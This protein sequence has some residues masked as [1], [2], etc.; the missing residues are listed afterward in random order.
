MYLR[1][2]ST[3]SLANQLL[4]ISSHATHQLNLKQ[5]PPG[6]CILNP[7]Y[8]WT[9]HTQWLLKLCFWHFMQVLT[10]SAAKQTQK[11]SEGRMAR[12]KPT[13]YWLTCHRV[14]HPA[15]VEMRTN[16][17]PRNRRMWVRWTNCFACL[18]CVGYVYL[19][20]LWCSFCVYWFFIV[21]NFVCLLVTCLLL[22]AQ[23][24]LLS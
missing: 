23:L 11:T 16:H 1:E 19:R 4:Q 24:L 21:G 22:S 2:R 17:A 5:R 8:M 10:K 14:I 6:L 3:S 9:H 20:R 18:A 7:G 13:K 12:T 15:K